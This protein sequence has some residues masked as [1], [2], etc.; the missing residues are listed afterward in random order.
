MT[1]DTALLE[2]VKTNIAGHHVADF[3]VK[4]K[5]L[6]FEKKATIEMVERYFEEE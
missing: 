6:G 5:E 1:E 2:Q 4:M 3:S